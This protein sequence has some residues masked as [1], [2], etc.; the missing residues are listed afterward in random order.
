M[1]ATKWGRRVQW[2]CVL[3][4]TLPFLTGCWDRLEIEERATVLGIAVDEAGPETEAE[5]DEIS[6]I[7]GKFPV[8]EKEVIRITTQIAVPGRIPLGPG[9][10]G[11]GGGERTQSVWVVN[12]VGHTFEDAMMSLQQKVSNRLFFGHLRIIIVSEAIARKGIENLNDYLRRDPEVRRMAWMLVSKG[13]A[14]KLMAVVPQLERV[15]TLYMMAILDQA[16]KM[17]KF[18]NDF[19]GIFWSNL[20]KKGQEPFLPY[21]EIKQKDNIQISGMAYFRGEKM[22]GVTKPLEVGFYMAVKGIDPGGYAVV[23]PVP[24]LPGTVMFQ[25]THRVSKIYVDMKNGRPHFI[26]KV[27]LEG[28]LLEKSNERFAVDNPEMIVKIQE[29][30][31]KRAKRGFEDLIQKTQEQRADIFGF[32]EYV[33]AKQPRYWNEQIQTKSKWQEAYKEIPVDV[34]V[35][36]NIRRIGMKAK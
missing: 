5:E 7:E 27:H 8:P 16:V 19:L 21:I 12:A 17:G 23:A 24:G 35:K 30:I 14:S 33:R 18:P 20:S 36:I 22:V 1:Q 28:N 31:A 6:H 26:V 4:V 10:G 32:G 13:K 29:E 25:S 34:Y 11:G 2:L 15:P 3:L 9:E